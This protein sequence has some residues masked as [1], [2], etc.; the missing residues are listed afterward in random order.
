MLQSIMSS[1]AL[2][3]SPSSW[4]GSGAKLPSPFHTSNTLYSLSSS[5]TIL[6]TK[7]FIAGMSIHPTVKNNAAMK[8]ACFTTLD[9][10]GVIKYLAETP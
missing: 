1:I 6:S 2:I 9:L 5:G 3:Y 8:K 7:P 10:G 4:F